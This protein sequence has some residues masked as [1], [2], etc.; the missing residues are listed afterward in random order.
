MLHETSI[1]G[2][3]ESAI[4]GSA[5]S[6]RADGGICGRMGAKKCSDPA[7]RRHRP[8]NDSA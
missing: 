7:G 5:G 3:T 2:N 4:T 1:Q 6:S 8:E